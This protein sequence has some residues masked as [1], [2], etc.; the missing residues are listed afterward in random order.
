MDHAWNASLA[1]Q[2]I[3]AVV[4]IASFVVF[5]RSSGM[6]IGTIARYAGIWIL[7]ALAIAVAYT[8]RDDV[9]AFGDRMLAD[10]IPSRGMTIGPKSIVLRAANDRHFRVDAVVDGK[11]IEMLV[12]TGATTVSL[13]RRD[14]QRIGIDLSRLTYNRR[15]MTANGPALTAPV[16]LREVRVG[17]ITLTDVHAAVSEERAEGSLLGMSFL[18]RLQSYA[19]E[20]DKLTLTGP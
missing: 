20:G 7:I 5:V 17:P 4:L 10:L 2:I 1:Y 14:A 9:K 3:L 11:S 15:V 13:S 8:L 12:D 6:R 19:I 16:T 18:G